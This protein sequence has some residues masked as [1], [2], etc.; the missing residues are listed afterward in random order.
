V[1]DQVRDED[2]VHREA[3]PAEQEHRNHFR[4]QGP[5]EGDGCERQQGCGC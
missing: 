3:H 5:A 4:Q 1:I 2:G